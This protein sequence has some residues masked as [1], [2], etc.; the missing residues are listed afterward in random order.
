MTGR[1]GLAILVAVAVVLAVG[2]AF[3]S[4]R[5]PARA[6]A[7]GGDASDVAVEC[8][9][10]AGLDDAR[11]GDW[12]TERLAEGPPSN[13]FEMKDLGRLALTRDWLGLAGPCHAVYYLSRYAD[14]P[15]WSEETPCP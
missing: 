4:L 14:E 7:S 11:C 1:R 9:A 6:T 12:G 13:T 8:A 2:I 10:G 3:F 5:P 15:V